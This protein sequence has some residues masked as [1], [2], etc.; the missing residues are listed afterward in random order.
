MASIGQD[1]VWAAVSSVLEQSHPS[2]S[3][4]LRNPSISKTEVL[5]MSVPEFKSKNN[6]GD[7]D[8]NVLSNSAPCQQI[9]D[10]EA[11]C[12]KMQK[13]AVLQKTSIIQKDRDLVD[14]SSEIAQ[15]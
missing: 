6:V 12:L 8:V 7:S 9:E 2:A 5:N 15:L 14:M 1:E 11:K 13:K 10:M 4:A 3:H